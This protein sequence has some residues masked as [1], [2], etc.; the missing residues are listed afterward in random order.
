MIFHFLLSVVVNA[1]I[2]ILIIT[3][4]PIAL[5]ITPPLFDSTTPQS[6]S[7]LGTHMNIIDIFSFPGTGDITFSLRNTTYQNN[8]LVTLEDIG[9]GDN[10]ALLCITDLTTCCRPPYTG[11]EGTALGNWFFPNG[12]RVPSQEYQWDFYRDRKQMVVQMNRRR[13]GKEGVYCCEIPDSMNVTRTIHIG[14]YTANN[15]KWHCLYSP[16]LYIKLTV[17]RG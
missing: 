2:F 14:V 4:T 7:L 11:T 6:Q 13:G 17:D 12:T 3:I 15:G 8:S 10:D 5:F 16:V 1:A 9:D